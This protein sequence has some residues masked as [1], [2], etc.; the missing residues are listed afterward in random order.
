MDSWRGST[1]SPDLSAGAHV[2]LA[3]SFGPPTSF[4]FEESPDLTEVGWLENGRKM[5]MKTSTVFLMAVILLLANVNVIVG[6]QTAVEL[7]RR[8]KARVNDY[9]AGAKVTVFLKDGTKVR[10]SI[11]QILDDSFDV[12]LNDQTQSSII[13]YRDVQ[14]VKRRGWST[15]AKVTVGGLIGAAALVGLLMATLSA[16]DILGN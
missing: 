11:G 5:F 10:G 15:T 7:D 8:I 4:V 3:D 2:R 14:N 9:G 6:Q 12:T 13:S 16:D 1:P